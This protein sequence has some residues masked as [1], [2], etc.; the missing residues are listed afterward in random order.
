MWERRP[1]SGGS[2][3]SKRERY[4]RDVVARGARS[5]SGIRAFCEREGVSTASYYNWR[6]RFDEAGEVK[7][8]ELPLFVP[9]RVGEES[10][11]AVASATG[12]GSTVAVGAAVEVA[13]PSGV[14]VRVASGADRGTIA[15]VLAALGVTG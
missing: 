7:D 13:L 5:G 6:R 12:R 2:V 10:A 9:V 14:I 4:W 11:C 8:G 15:D 3:V 1:W